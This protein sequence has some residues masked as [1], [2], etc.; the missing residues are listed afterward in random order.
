MR[1]RG[2][3]PGTLVAVAT[4]LIGILIGCVGPSPSTST[5]PASPTVGPTGS[6][7]CAAL[8]H[9]PVAERSEP[10]ARLPVRLDH[11]AGEHRTT[12]A[13]SGRTTRPTSIG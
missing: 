3:R 9:T 4:L 12:T 2:S 10:T 11:R 1:D 6:T 13:S 8:V 5:P 7:V